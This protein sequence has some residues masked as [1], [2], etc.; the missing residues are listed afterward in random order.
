MFAIILLVVLALG[1]GY[2]AI[3][4]AQQTTIMLTGYAFPSV[5][6]YVVIGITLLLGL[7]FSWILSLV[8]GLSTSM[9]LRGKEHTIKDANKNVSELTKKVNELEVENA[10][11]KGQLEK[12][13]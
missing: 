9:K 12:S 2:F 11:L 7:L 1:F 13:P 8:N 6:L 5:P 10:K 4:N 3:Q